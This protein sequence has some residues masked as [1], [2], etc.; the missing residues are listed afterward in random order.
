M[1]LAG[2]DTTSKTIEWTMAELVKN[3]SEME[4]V[5]Q[6]VR[7]VVLSV[8]EHESWRRMWRK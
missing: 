4:K 3:P 6:E 8:H 7:R 1:F 2:T 5:Q